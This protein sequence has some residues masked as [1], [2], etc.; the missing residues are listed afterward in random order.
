MVEE[1]EWACQAEV[2]MVTCSKAVS[3]LFYISR[4]DCIVSGGHM[5]FSAGCLLSQLCSQ[6]WQTLKSSGT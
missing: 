6:V 2:D 5:S 3:L 4:L 1:D